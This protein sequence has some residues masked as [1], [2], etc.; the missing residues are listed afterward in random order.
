MF[1]TTEGR[2]FTIFKMSL[3]GYA[4]WIVEDILNLD[5]AL[6]ETEVNAVLQNLEN[7]SCLTASLVK[8]NQTTTCVSVRGGAVRM[9]LFQQ[10][11]RP[12]FLPVLR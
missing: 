1:S 8:Q 12:S 5:P 7:K 6:V 3:G 2:L 10:R 11:E 9:S 4:D